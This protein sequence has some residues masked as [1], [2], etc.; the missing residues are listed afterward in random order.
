[1]YAHKYYCLPLL[2][3]SGQ[4]R[5][6]SSMEAGERGGGRRL[7]LLE[8]PGAALRSCKLQPWMWIPHAAMV[9]VRLPSYDRCVIYIHRAELQAVSNASTKGW[10]TIDRV[11]AVFLT[12][13]GSMM[14]VCAFVHL[15]VLFFI[16]RCPFC[17]NT[18]GMHPELVILFSLS[19]GNNLM[20]TAIY[21][22]LQHIL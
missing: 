15:D 14:H 21:F 10:S 7:V 13:K 8:T 22:L 5:R 9:V 3:R 16:G 4:P 18:C 17:F 19:G 11:S 20:V 2:S 6:I 1:M 12:T